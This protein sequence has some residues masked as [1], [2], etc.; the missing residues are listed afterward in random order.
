[1]ENNL[2][3]LS[4]IRNKSVKRRRDLIR[5]RGITSKEDLEKQIYDS[6][7]LELEDLNN[8]FVDSLEIKERD[9]EMK[10]LNKLNNKFVDSL[11]FKEGDNEMKLL[12]KLNNKFVILLKRDS[13]DKVLAKL[14]KELNNKFVRSLKNIEFSNDK[15]LLSCN[16]Q[17]R[18]NF[19][20]Y[21]E[22]QTNF[23]TCKCCGEESG[24]D[25]MR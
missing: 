3:D 18:S 11:D 6:E 25:K 4:K 19:H 17:D 22:E 21:Y 8:K 2:V 12:N 7:R 5:T 1:M 10:L 14:L 15:F 13:E 9:N 16:N 24:L 23:K 20:K